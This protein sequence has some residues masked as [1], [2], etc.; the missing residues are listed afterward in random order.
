MMIMLYDKEKSVYEKK[1][2]QLRVTDDGICV[3]HIRVIS[4]ETWDNNTGLL[5]ITSHHIIKQFF[6][7]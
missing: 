2:I 5:T 3:I 1:F 6:I 7:L 4:C